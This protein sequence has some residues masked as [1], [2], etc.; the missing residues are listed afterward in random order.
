MS[1]NRNR[2][3]LNRR[4]AERVLYILVILGLLL[5]GLLRDSEVAARLMEAITNA[6]SVLIQNPS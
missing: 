5:Y 4:T 6:C 3:K 1:E 2:P